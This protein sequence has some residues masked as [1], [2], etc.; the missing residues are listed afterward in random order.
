MEVVSLRPREKMDACV[1]K[2]YLGDAA[3]V[4]ISVSLKGINIRQDRP[5]SRK[6]IIEK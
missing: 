5:V 4:T 2:M 6:E 1:M 3:H